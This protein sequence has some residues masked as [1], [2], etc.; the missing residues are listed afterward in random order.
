MSANSRI[1][2][3]RE[4]GWALP[5]CSFLGLPSCPLSAERE[6]ETSPSWGTGQGE[7]AE[8]AGLAGAGPGVSFASFKRGKASN[9]WGV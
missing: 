8:L 7:T 9:G 6:R 5:V 2:E 4:P 1:Q 3:T